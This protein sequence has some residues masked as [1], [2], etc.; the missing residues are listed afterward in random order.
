M[1]N[2]FHTNKKYTIKLYFNN[3]IENIIISSD[4]L[5]PELRKIIFDK[6]LLSN[7]NYTIFYRNKKLTMNNLNKVSYYFE[8]EPIPFLFII[9][10]K[11]LSQNCNQSSSVFITT[12]ENEKMISEILGRFFEYKS[13][14]F[15]VDIKLLANKKFRIR[16][17]SPILAEE[18]IQFYNIIN[19]KKN[20]NKAE[21]K[22]PKIKNNFNN[23]NKIKQST[24]SENIVDYNSRENILNKVIMN[25]TR[26]SSIS[27]RTVKSG[28]DI[29]HPF[30]MKQLQRVPNLKNNNKKRKIKIVKNDYK[31]IFKLPFLNPDEKY[32]RE[33]FMDKKNW[34]DKKGFFV[35][36]GKYKMGGNNYISNYVCASP[37]EP[38][39]NHNFREVNKNKWI[40]KKGFFL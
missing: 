35:S 40:N 37:S 30:Y 4:A 25:N 2:D 23:N 24:S 29:L 27:F 12:N 15:N 6:F 10:N 20:N 17:T 38:P 7:F 34:I 13:L 16:F 8:K 3:R 19:E 32:Y 22:L 36:V 11:I 28:L 39:L 18:F 33:K 26:E 31:G 5:I 9:N 14:P 1:D 21:L